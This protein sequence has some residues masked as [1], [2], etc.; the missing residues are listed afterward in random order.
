[1]FF[2]A[3]SFNHSIASWN[4]SSVMEM[5]NMFGSLA[6]TTSHQTADNSGGGPAEV[7]SKVVVPATIVIRI[8]C[9]TCGLSAFVVAVC[10]CSGGGVHEALCEVPP[11]TDGHVARTPQILYQAVDTGI[12]E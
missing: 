8:I 9:L 1:M 4:M 6:S 10:L 7:P 12:D 11:E 5:D 3:T 2:G